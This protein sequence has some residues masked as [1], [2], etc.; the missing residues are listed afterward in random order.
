MIVVSFQLLLQLFYRVMR[1]VTAFF[2]VMLMVMLMNDGVHMRAAV[3]CVRKGMPV[4][5]CMVSDQQKL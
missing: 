2:S 1:P 3:M 5:M 4:R